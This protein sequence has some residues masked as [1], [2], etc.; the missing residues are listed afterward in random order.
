MIFTV[1]IS[2]VGVTVALAF[3]VTLQGPVP[4]QRPDQPA[5]VEPGLAVAVSVTAVPLGRSAVQVVVQL[6]PEGLL[7]T[8]PDPV[9]PG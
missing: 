6:T 8:V 9:P 4:V 3:R 2:K 1:P 7:V 5:N